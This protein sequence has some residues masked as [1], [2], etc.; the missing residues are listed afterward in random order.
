MRLLT[1]MIA[2]LS[3][4]FLAFSATIYVPDNYATIQGAIDAAANGDTVIVRAGTYIE[5]VTLSTKDILLKS[6]AGP[7]LTTIDGNR[8]GSVITVYQS[9]VNLESSL[10]G[11]NIVNGDFT[12]GGGIY[13]SESNYVIRDCIISKNDAG[14]G[15]GIFVQHCDIVIS[16]TL[17]DDNFAICTGGG[18]ECSLSNVA[19]SNSVI[20]NNEAEDNYG[21][22]G[23]ITSNSGNLT[24]ENTAIIEND[25]KYGEDGGLHCAHTDLIMT[26]CVLYANTALMGAGGMFFHGSDAHAIVKNSIFWENWSDEIQLSNGATFAISH[27]DVDGGQSSV[28]VGSGCTLDWGAGMIDADPRFIDTAKGDYHLAWNSPCRDVGDNTA[29]TQAFDFEGDP[30]IAFGTV[31]MGAD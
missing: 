29:A 23:G 21:W 25:A 9:G 18:I 16:D 6:E 19:I 28:H 31:D 26:N 20:S 8:D 27:S 15:A 11:F 4:Q 7:R 24:L 30:R 14:F 22:G 13:C 12:C 5:N 2:F 17:V 1:A 10:D 3:I